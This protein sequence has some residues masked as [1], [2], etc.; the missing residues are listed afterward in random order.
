M[1]AI[2][3]GGLCLP[4]FQKN[5]QN[6]NETKT[7]DHIQAILDLDLQEILVQLALNTNQ[8]LGTAK[9]IYENGLHAKMVAQ[10]TL[11]EALV[12]PIMATAQVIGQAESGAQVLGTV[13]R[14]YKAG[15]QFIKIEYTVQSS[16]VLQDFIIVKC[17]VGGN[18]LEPTTEGCKFYLGGT[19]LLCHGLKTPSFWVPSICRLVFSTDSV[20]F[21]KV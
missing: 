6:H 1:C 9:T 13:V 7:V 20:W 21:W 3:S 16:S 12:F 2:L 17:R 18:T 8:S 19:G 5:N 15:S 10:I 14:D 11:K 4:F